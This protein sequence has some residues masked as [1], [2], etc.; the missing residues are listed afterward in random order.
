LGLQFQIVQDGGNA[1]AAGICEGDLCVSVN[2]MLIKN[3]SHAT[4]VDTLKN[5]QPPLTI[6]VSSL[7]ETPTTAP[8]S[9]AA[10][11]DGKAGDAA[12]A[13]AASDAVDDDSSHPPLP[14]S[15]TAAMSTLA[16]TTTA[17]TPTT[18]TVTLRRGP[19]GYGMMVG[20]AKDDGTG[21]AVAEIIPGGAAAEC[22]VLR[23]GDVVVAINGVRVVDLAHVEARQHMVGTTELVLELARRAPSVTQ[24]QSDAS[25]PPPSLS[26]SSL[27]ASDDVCCRTLH[28]TVVRVTGIHSRRAFGMEVCSASADGE[29]GLC[30]VA[31]AAVSAAA[32]A[33]LT[34]GDHIVAIDGR[35]LSDLATSEAVK[36][37][38]ETGSSFKFTIA[39][40]S[41]VWAV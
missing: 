26:S 32:D 1:H 23:E 31:V 15:S 33:G 2:G 35:N 38:G 18:A 21:V 5:A 29:R 37:L 6:L 19:D 10:E 9:H 27:S 24:V 28:D 8:R 7:V 39:R 25:L 17:A 16:S 41:R 30:V 14:P 36:A 11:S 34:A 22:G 12:V 20:P 3:V 4:A 13:S 40:P